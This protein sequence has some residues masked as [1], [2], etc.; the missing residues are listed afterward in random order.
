M[1]RKRTRRGRKLRP[2]VRK[3]RRSQKGG[4]ILKKDKKGE[5][6]GNSENTV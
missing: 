4:F 5:A 1:T 6:A 3:A 2:W